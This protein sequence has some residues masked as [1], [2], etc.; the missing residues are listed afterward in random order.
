MRLFLTL[1]AL[2]L[3][4]L[5]GCGGTSDSKVTPV[6]NEKEVHLIKPEDLKGHLATLMQQYRQVGLNIEGKEYTHLQMLSADAKTGIINLKFSEGIVRMVR[7]DDEIK[8]MTLILGEFKEPKKWNYLD[9]GEFEATQILQ[10]RDG[11]STDLNED[12]VAFEA[13]LEDSTTNELYAVTLRFNELLIAAGNA[14][15][16]LEGDTVKVAG[17]LGWKTYVDLEN[18]LANNPNI[19]RFE[20][21]NVSGSDDDAVNMHTGRLIRQHKLE[22]YVANGNQAHSG[23]VDLFAAGIIRTAE[24]NAILG[25]HSWCCSDD[26]KP[27]NQFPENH[28]VHGAQLTYF[29]EMLGKTK[30]PEF[31]FFTINAANPNETH[32]MTRAEMEKYSLVSQ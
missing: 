7:A 17:S 29:R 21:I 8:E 2:T 20:L 26:D 30:G 6:V 3:V 28:P 16:E 32:K 5:S 31:Y 11:I 10:F 25:V 24:T 18:L 23:G 1:S 27:A 19:T 22:T 4:L 9:P 15:L 14:T 13:N 12:T